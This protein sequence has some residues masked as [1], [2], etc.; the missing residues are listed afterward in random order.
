MS[1]YSADV[2]FIKPILC[3]GNVGEQTRDVQQDFSISRDRKVDRKFESELTR[4]L[5]TL[6][7]MF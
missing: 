1:I 5:P 7:S 2:L 4:V 3:L 6:I